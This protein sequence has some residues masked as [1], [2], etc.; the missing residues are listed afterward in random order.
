MFLGQ[1]FAKNAKNDPKTL[2]EASKSVKKQ[3]SEKHGKV[4]KW[5][6]KCLF[7]TCFMLYLS[8]FWRYRLENFVHIFM[9]YCPLTYVTVFWKFWFGRKLF[10][11]DVTDTIHADS[12]ALFELNNAILLADVTKPEKSNI[13]TLTWPVTSLVTP[14]S[15]K[16]VFLRQFF[17]GL[18]NAVWIFYNDPISM[19]TLNPRWGRSVVCSRSCLVSM[20][21]LKPP[22]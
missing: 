18:S 10:R 17:P 9:R 20:G 4:S 11:T 5:R 21:T 13:F 12:L 2:F 6:E 8:H 14:R 3:N 16:F 19:G 15:I 1:I 22:L 7:L